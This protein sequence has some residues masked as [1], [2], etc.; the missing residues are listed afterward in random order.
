MNLNIQSRNI[1]QIS[2][3]SEMMGENLFQLNS[4][5][6]N[7]VITLGNKNFN[8]PFCNLITLFQSP[9]QIN[10]NKQ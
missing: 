4:T 7:Y 9:N 1:N 10:P 8:S 2:N 3:I 6:I 5:K